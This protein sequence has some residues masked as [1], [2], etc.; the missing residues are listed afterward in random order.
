MDELMQQSQK[1]NGSSKRS[2]KCLDCD[3]ASYSTLLIDLPGSV[4]LATIFEIH[5]P[6]PGGGRSGNFV[7]SDHFDLKCVQNVCSW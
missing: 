3:S 6:R 4:Q 7:S 2:K 5:E 1:S